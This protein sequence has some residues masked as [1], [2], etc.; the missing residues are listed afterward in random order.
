MDDRS[1]VLARYRPIEMACEVLL[2]LDGGAGALEG[3][4]SLLGGLLGD[5]LENGLRGAVHEVL[6]LL[7]TQG[8]QLT[9][10]LDDLDL[11]LA[12]TREGDVELVL[13]LSGLDGGGGAGRTGN[14]DRGGGGDVELVLERLHELGELDEGHVLELREQ[15][16]LAE[17]RHDGRSFHLFGWCRDVHVRRAYFRPAATTAWAELL[18]RRSMR[19]PNYSAPP[20]SACL[21]RRA[22]T[23]RTSFEGSAWK[24]WA[25]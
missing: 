12:G 23:V 1:S 16:F 7:Q 10:D 18:R 22:S 20:C 15:V 9:H 14:G 2:D 5:L 8:G 25:A 4:G 11:L 17:L 24:S 21:A 19:E 3:L 13:L 6:G